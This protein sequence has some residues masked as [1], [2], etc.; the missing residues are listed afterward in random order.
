MRGRPPARFRLALVV[1]EHESFV[2]C[3]DV[4][5]IDLTDK[6]YDHLTVLRY[7][8]RDPKTRRS[9]WRCKCACGNE[10]IVD[11]VRL[12]TRDTKSCGCQQFVGL[13]RTEHGATKNRKMT[14]EYSLWLGMKQRCT[15]PKHKNYENYG[16]RGIT[17]C[18]KWSE[19]FEAF[20][21]DM[22]ERPSEGLTLERMD[23]DKPYEPGNVRWATRLEQAQNR[24][25]SKTYTVDGVAK[26]IGEWSTSHH[27]PYQTIVA[28]LGRNGRDMK[29]AL[30]IE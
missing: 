11:G 2:H 17:V 8:G 30:G 14:T 28:R 5:R 16:G 3:T 23:N 4:F 19:S 22:G 18:E 25:S 27:I 10:C 15:N 7:E 12:T 21:K 13:D 24:R 20:L 1:D 29:K 26:T 6:T 9:L